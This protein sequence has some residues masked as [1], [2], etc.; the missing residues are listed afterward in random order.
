M[1][2][3]SEIPTQEQL[4]QLSLVANDDVKSP[5]QEEEKKS[6]KKK[7]K[8]VPIEKRLAESKKLL[9][10]KF[11]SYIEGEEFLDKF[12]CSLQK[13]ILLSGRVHV[14]T[15]RLIFHS[16]FNDKTLFG[17][18]TVVS[19]PYETIIHFE[20]KCYADMKM[21]PNSIYIK[22]QTEKGEDDFFLTSFSNRTICY[23][24]VIKYL[25]NLTGADTSPGQSG[26]STVV[27]SSSDTSS[28]EKE[29]HNQY[30]APT[31]MHSDG[32]LPPDAC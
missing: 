1:K 30:V 18:G 17:R 31:D 20:K 6:N 29:S 24:L 9:M 11:K 22:I 2:P 27:I 28:Q 21:F 23:D 3:I 14:T 4:A 26:G 32:N 19:I 7:V 10:K 25:T 12:T 8:E 13:K 15:K 5:L 16:L